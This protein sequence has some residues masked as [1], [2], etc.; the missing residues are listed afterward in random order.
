MLRT[1]RWILIN[2]CAM[3][4]L[5]AMAAPGGAP[6]VDCRLKRLA[7]LDLSVSPTRVYVPVVVDGT[8]AWMTLNIHS[9]MTVMWR[10]SA[11]RLRLK[12]Q[13]LQGFQNIHFGNKQISESAV[14]QVLALGTLQLLKAQFLLVPVT[15]AESAELSNPS[16]DVGALGLDMF[17]KV[18]FELDFANKKLNL[19]SQEHCP[20]AVVYWA[21]SYAS[22]PFRRGSLGEA[23]F[24]FEIEG[25]KIAASLS[26]GTSITT[27][28]TDATKR[29]YGFD[30]HSA[31][32]DTSRDSQG[33]VTA[34]YRAMAITTPGLK[35]TNTQIQLAKPVKECS[36][37]LRGRGDGVAQYFNCIGNEAPLHIGLN[38]LEKLHLYFA[39]RENVLYFTAAD[40]QKPLSDSPPPS[41]GH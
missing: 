38:V 36:L 40:A 20:G 21:D 31:D 39:T 7:S 8:P 14:A 35:V 37:Q 41:A 9:S 11:A 3:F 2:M 33:N 24:P 32:I 16:M 22:A 5:P 12:M 15:A 6:N 28:T 18:D 13:S 19:Y 17:S 10:P 34:Q 25:K 1:T 26:T 23:Y 29:L 27:L 30:E 4:A